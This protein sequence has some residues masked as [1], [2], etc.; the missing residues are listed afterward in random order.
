VK[1]ARSNI[2]A[3]VRGKDKSS[4]TELWR[5]DGQPRRIG[6]FEG[7]VSDLIIDGPDLYW[8]R[9]VGPGRDSLAVGEVRS[10]PVDGGPPGPTAVGFLRAVRDRVAYVSRYD[11]QATYEVKLGGTERR[12]GPCVLHGGLVGPRLYGAFFGPHSGRE[13]IGYID[14][15][16]H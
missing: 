5:L 9:S 7:L 11:A 1:A 3:V 8:D 4:T 15:G 6:T 2:A 14:V 16:A 12:I 10:Q 13:V